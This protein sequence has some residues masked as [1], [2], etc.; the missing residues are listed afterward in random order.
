MKNIDPPEP[1]EGLIV[2]HVGAKQGY[3]PITVS[4]EKGCVVTHW[5]LNEDEI[6]KLLFGAPLILSILGDR[7]P[8]ILLSVGE[9]PPQ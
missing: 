1:E 4:Y 5:Q 6:G 2:R 9:I 8:P 7:Q 3:V